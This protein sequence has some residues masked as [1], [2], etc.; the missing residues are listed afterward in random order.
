MATKAEKFHAAQERSGEKKAPAPKRPR[1]D[2]VVDTSKP[3]V[4]A[5]DRK[6]TRGPGGSA[7]TSKR[8]AKKGGAALEGAATEQ[9]PSRKS[10]RASE[11]RA[12]RTSNLE[13]RAKRKIAAPA[14]RADRGKASR[15]ASAKAKAKTK[16]AA[17]RGKGG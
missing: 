2:T 12:K 14:A 6:A 17:P 1:R 8:A 16:R 4:S 3:G 11:G 15:T 9:K 7:N 5:T 10:T 13:R